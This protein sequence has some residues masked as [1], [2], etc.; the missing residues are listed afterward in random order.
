MSSNYSDFSFSYS[1]LSIV[2]HAKAQ[3]LEAACKVLEITIE[4]VS[5]AT[6]AY[7]AAKE[8]SNKAAALEDRLE[9]ASEADPS[10]VMSYLEA[11]TLRNKAD[12]DKNAALSVLL[13]AKKESVGALKEVEVAKVTAAEAS[14][15]ALAARVE[16]VHDGVRGVLEVFVGGNLAATFYPCSAVT[17]YLEASVEVVDTHSQEYVYL[18]P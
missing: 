1:N 13:S 7:E 2:A 9:A 8:L 5:L 10:L 14:D 18:L 3:V 15:A 6:S 16:I 17:Y 12:M 11:M 4:A